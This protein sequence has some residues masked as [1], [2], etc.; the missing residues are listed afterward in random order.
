MKEG[1]I[2]ERREGRC[3][4][5]PNQRVLRRLPARP[6]LTNRDYRGHVQ[7]RLVRPVQ[8]ELGVLGRVLEVRSILAIDGAQSLQIWWQICKLPWRLGRQRIDCQA[9]F[10]SC[11][12]L[13]ARK[14]SSDH[15]FVRS[16][17]NSAP[18]RWRKFVRLLNAAR[19]FEPGRPGRCDT[20][21]IYRAHGVR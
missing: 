3:H 17:P 4:R 7:S 20:K 11:I 12:F 5:R 8:E 2:K 16:R 10:L 14:L 6:P 18:S 1:R 15:K 19:V 21:C 9:L 13:A